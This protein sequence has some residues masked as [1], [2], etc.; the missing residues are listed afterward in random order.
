MGKK[1][2]KG[3]PGRL[4][5]RRF[6]GNQFQKSSLLLDAISLEEAVAENVTPAVD[7]ADS[8]SE[9]DDSSSEEDISDSNDVLENNPNTSG[10][11]LIDLECLAIFVTGN[12]VCKYCHG[13]VTFQES[14]RD[15][16][17]TTQS[18]E[19]TACK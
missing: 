9:V 4:K 15:G 13:P 3:R 6:K 16:M 5:K 17:A 12:L 2:Y 7:E 19:C 1:Q 18:I 8:M 10:F 11:C 14:R